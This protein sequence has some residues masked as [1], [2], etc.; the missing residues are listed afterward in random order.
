[1]TTI[2]NIVRRARDAND[3]DIPIEEQIGEA[4]KKPAT[5]AKPVPPAK[6]V[7]MDEPVEALVKHIT[8]V[9]NRTHKVATDECARAR[10][11]V[12]QAGRNALAV[13]D[14]VERA[15]A[16]KKDGTT[17]QFSAY[18][19]TVRKAQTTAEDVRLSTTEMMTTMQQAISKVGEQVRTMP[20]P[21]PAQDGQSDG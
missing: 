7:A 14:E 11:A 9:V 20:E 12:E 17:H 16:A 10:A 19:E 1:M 8:D 2:S 21:K 5:P 13:I 4:L 6:P 18:I 3:A 15:I